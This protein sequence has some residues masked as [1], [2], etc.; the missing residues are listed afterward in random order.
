MAPTNPLS[1]LAEAAAEAAKKEKKKK[2]KEAEKAKTNQ[3]KQFIDSTTFDDVARGGGV[4]ADLNGNAVVFGDT[5]ISNL[6]VMVFDQVTGSHLPPLK[7]P[8]MKDTIDYGTQTSAGSDDII[9]AMLNT[10]DGSTRWLHQ[11]GSNGDDRVA[12][13][14]GIVA[15][16]NGNAVVFGDTTGSFY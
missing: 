3:Q 11:V 1:S 12:R 7:A 2:Q 14:G 9:V 6:F 13:G 5:D 4:V 16:L 8:P 10:N 15:D